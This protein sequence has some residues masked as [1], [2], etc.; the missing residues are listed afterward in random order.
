MC[1]FLPLKIPED[2]DEFSSRWFHGNIFAKD[3]KADAKAIPKPDLSM[4]K[5]SEKATMIWSQFFLTQR[6]QSSPIRWV[7][8][9]VDHMRALGKLV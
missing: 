3:T 6:Q 2:I 4:S 9:V 1:Y 7:L 8:L 5:A